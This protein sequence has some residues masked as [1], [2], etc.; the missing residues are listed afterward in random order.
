MQVNYYYFF[1][2]S[3][4]YFKSVL[5]TGLYHDQLS[6][7]L[8]TLFQIFGKHYNNFKWSCYSILAVLSIDLRNTTDLRT[9]PLPTRISSSVIVSELDDREVFTGSVKSVI[10]LEDTSI[11][12]HDMISVHPFYESKKTNPQ[13]MSVPTYTGKL[14]N[15][16]S[17]I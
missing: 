12:F 4:F 9:F 1:Y 8:F 2:F 11:C 17:K 7:G 16:N 13:S 6:K 5:C 10:L 14:N 3:S 15:D